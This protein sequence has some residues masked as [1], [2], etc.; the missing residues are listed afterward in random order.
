MGLFLTA[1]TGFFAVSPKV[2]HQAKPKPLVSLLSPGVNSFQKATS[3][4]ICTIFI[5]WEKWGHP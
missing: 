1:F 4:Q 5:R 3:F 2:P